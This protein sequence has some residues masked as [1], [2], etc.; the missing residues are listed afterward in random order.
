MTEKSENISDFPLAKFSKE[1]LEDYQKKWEEEWSKFRKM[2]SEQRWPLS[3]FRRE[4]MIFTNKFNSKALNIPYLSDDE[5]LRKLVE[6]ITQ[7]KKVDPLKE[8]PSN[9]HADYA[10]FSK[11]IKKLPPEQQVIAGYRWYA[12]NK[13]L[14]PTLPK[15][16]DKYSRTRLVGFITFAMFFGLCLGYQYTHRVA[17][18]EVA[19]REDYFDQIKTARKQAVQ[20]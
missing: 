20:E 3:K 10:K 17:D 11:E 4:A 18:V 14:K 7:S 9:L 8:I 15:D 6:E 12:K 2:S 13:L 5:Q 19:K 1:E 16:L